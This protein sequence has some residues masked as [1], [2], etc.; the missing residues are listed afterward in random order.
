MQRKDRHEV[1]IYMTRN[2]YK[3]IKAILVK[4]EP[5]G[6]FF[7]MSHSTSLEENKKTTTSS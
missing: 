3:E 4:F 5:M 7:M 2:A 1:H 6:S